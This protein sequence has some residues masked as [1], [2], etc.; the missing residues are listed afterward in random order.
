[1]NKIREETVAFPGLTQGNPP[2][3]AAIEVR[4][5]ADVRRIDV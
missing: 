4:D 3:I 5:A 2:S 1:M